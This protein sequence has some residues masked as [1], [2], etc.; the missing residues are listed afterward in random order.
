MFAGLCACAERDVK[1]VVA[2]RTLSQLGVMMIS[3][4]ALEKTLCFFH[5]IS[6]A[7]FKALLFMCVGVCIHSVY[8]TQDYRSFM[9][10]NLWIVVFVIVSVLSL[11][12]FVFFDG[13]RK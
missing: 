7:F 12:G 1:K 5:L 11:I 4:G 3:L 8:G 6:H 13:I 2:L 9:Q 10:P